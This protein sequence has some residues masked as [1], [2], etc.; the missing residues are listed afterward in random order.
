VMRGKDMV[1]LGRVVIA[2]HER[3]IM[4]QPPWEKGLMGT[5]LRYPLRA[6]GFE[7]IL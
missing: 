4:L 1:A 5:S 2:K 3:V 6:Q 7:R